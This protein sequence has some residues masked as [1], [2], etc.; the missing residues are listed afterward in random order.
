MGILILIA[1]N[2]PNDLI[3]SVSHATNAGDLA[4]MNCRPE[5]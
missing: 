3:E 2:R 5:L 4:T 1:P